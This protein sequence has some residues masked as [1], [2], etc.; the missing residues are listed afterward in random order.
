M[1][2][3]YYDMFRKASQDDFYRA[4]NDAESELYDVLWSAFEAVVI[5]PAEVFDP[6]FRDLNQFRYRIGDGFAALEFFP[7]E[8]YFLGRPGPDPYHDNSDAA[9]VHLKLSVLPRM[10]C[11]FCA[12][13]G[14]WGEAEREAFRQLWVRHRTVLAGLFQRAKPIMFTSIL[15]PEVEYARNL[16]EMLDRYFKIHDPD[17]LLEFQYS[18]PQLDETSEAENFMTYMA[19]LYHM[20]RSYAHSGKD[21]TMMWVTRLNEF[22]SGYLPDL[23]APLPCVAVSSDVT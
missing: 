2:T 21:L 20:I 19:L 22:Y 23:P 1:H 9:G 15:F 16:E 5:E 11:L 6:D 18:F 10:S 3:R 4:I 14:I 13:L 17:S 12:S 8:A 7:D